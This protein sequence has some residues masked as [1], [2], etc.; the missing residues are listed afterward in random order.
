MLLPCMFGL[1]CMVSCVVFCVEVLYKSIIETSRPTGHVCVL[2]AYMVKFM[3]KIGDV[4]ITICFHIHSVQR[5]EGKQS[6]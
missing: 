3:T 5:N 4:K 2:F 1:P 6:N